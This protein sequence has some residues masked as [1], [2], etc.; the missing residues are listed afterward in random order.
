MDLSERRWTPQTVFE[1]KRKR[2]LGRGDLTT[3]NDPADISVVV[4]FDMRRGQRT[5]ARN[6]LK[7]TN[8]R[9]GLNGKKLLD[10]FK[11]GARASTELFTNVIPVN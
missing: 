6:E 10:L 2:D 7:R 1:V 11:T 9:R 8:R 3:R 4:F 5:S